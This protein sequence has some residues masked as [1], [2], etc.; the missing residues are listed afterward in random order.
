[1]LSTAQKNLKRQQA[2]VAASLDSTTAS[3]ENKN[4]SASKNDLTA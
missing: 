3:N 4:T 1:M 2:G